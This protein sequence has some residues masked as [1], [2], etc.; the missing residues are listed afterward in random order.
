MPN[1]DAPS[2]PPYPEYPALYERARWAAPKFVSPQDLADL[3]RVSRAHGHDWCTAVLGRSWA[4][5]RSVSVV[6]A[7]MLVLADQDGLNPPLPAKVLEHRAQ[8]VA[9]QERLAQSR[10]DL[11]ELDARRWARALEGTSVDLEVRENVHGRRYGMGLNT[12]PLRHAV[13]L[14]D[15]WS[16]PAS[17][18]RRHPAG[19]A[20]CETEGRAKPRV[21]SEPVQ[22]PATCQSCLAFVPQLRQTR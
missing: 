4:G 12:G 13:P 9:R 15:V 22:A 6:E 8:E 19:R 14:N 21:L 20:V 1:E 18:P 7:T 16:G 5:V 17:R 3:H 2:T 10:R 11:N